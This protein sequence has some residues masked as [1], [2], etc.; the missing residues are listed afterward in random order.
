M[1][2][3]CREK[4]SKR[5]QNDENPINIINNINSNDI[6]KGLV[7]AMAIGKFDKTVGVSQVLP[8]ATYIQT[9]LALRRIDSPKND[10]VASKLDH[11][12]MYGYTQV[13]FLCP[14]ETPE[15]KDVGFIKQLSIIGSI[16]TGMNSQIDVIK[17]LLEPYIT[18]VLD[19]IKPKYLYKY[20][21]VFL[22]GQL[23]GTVKKKIK[24][25]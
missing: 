25:I 7:S 1:I 5:N 18:P 24:F 17:K 3:G 22:N 21:K 8:R 13:G 15:H 2:N 19:I 23:Q 14:V 6:E 20:T 9:I 16:T 4:F 12:R 10:S 11:P